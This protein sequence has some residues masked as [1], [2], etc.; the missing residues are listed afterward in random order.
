MFTSTVMCFEP[1]EEKNLRFILNCKL[2]VY[3]K[4]RN[5]S[6]GHSV[7]KGYLQTDLHHEIR[8]SRWRK[9][10]QIRRRTRY[11]L[12]HPSI[13]RVQET[14]YYWNSQA[15]TRMLTRPYPIPQCFDPH[16]SIWNQCT[17][18]AL[19]WRVKRSQN[20]PYRISVS[21]WL[22]FKFM[23]DLPRLW[24]DSLS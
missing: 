10:R 13:P 2:K 5:A 18:K 20:L 24:L 21:F 9:S 17:Q 1:Q 3:P 14:I 15:I 7:S 22:V 19:P 11:S 23:N 16:S 12:L 6:H 4:H 8:S